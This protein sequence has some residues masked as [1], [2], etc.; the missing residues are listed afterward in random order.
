MEGSAGPQHA[1]DPQP[2]DHH[3]IQNQQA[4]PKIGVREIEPGQAVLA[5]IVKA[6]KAKNIDH[7]NNQAAGRYSNALHFPGRRKSQ[8][9]G[10]QMVTLT[11]IQPSRI[12][13]PKPPDAR[14]IAPSRAACPPQIWIRSCETFTRRRENT[15]SAD[16]TGGVNRI[17]N[18]SRRQAAKTRINRRGRRGRDEW[19]SFVNVWE[20]VGQQPD[21][22]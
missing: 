17:P 2:E 18:P 12:S 13:T 16:W 8:D 21:P 1:V 7:L 10:P 5:E 22:R 20:R 19:S 15:T 6:D 3:G 11:A 14:R 4:F 9:R